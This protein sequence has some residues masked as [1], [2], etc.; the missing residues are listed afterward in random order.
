MKVMFNWIYSI[1]DDTIQ[2]YVYPSPSTLG[3]TF[4][5]EFDT[6]EFRVE[7]EIKMKRALEKALEIDGPGAPAED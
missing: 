6:P 4:S 3:I 2:G 5:A 7:Q 1:D